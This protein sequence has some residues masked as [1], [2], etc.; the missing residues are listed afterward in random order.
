MYRTKTILSLIALAFIFGCSESD[1]RKVYNVKNF[2]AKNDGKTLATESIQSAIDKC[3]KDGGGQVLVPAGEYLVGTLNLKS[4][5]DFHIEAGATLIATT[6]LEKYQ[7]HNNHPAGVFYTEKADNVSISGRGKIFGQGMEYM[8]K[9]SAK[10]IGLDDRQFTRQGENFRRVAHGVGDGPLYPKERFHQMIIFSEC[11]RVSLSDF[12]CIDAPYWTILLV[13]C[14]GIE[15]HRVNIQNNLLIPNSDGLD[16]ISCSNANV[17]NCNFDCGDDALV[18]AGYATHFGDPGFK[19]ILRRSENIN[20]NNCIFRSRSSAI[21]IGGWDQNNMA[22]YNISNISIYDSNRGIN[23]GVG[24]SGSIQNINFTNITIETRLH[25]GDWWGQGDAIK[26]S[27]I[28]GVHENVPGIVKNINF[29]NISCTS[30]NGVIMYASDE[31]K[32]QN[33]FFNNFQ[34]NIKKSPM[35]KL[36]GGNHDLRP[37]IVPGKNIFASKIPAIYIENAD[38]VHFNQADISWDGQTEPYFTAAIEA[39]KVDGLRLYGVK[40]KSS[41]SNP[42]MSAVILNDCIDFYNSNNKLTVSY[43]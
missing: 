18:L 13:H 33:I 38:N 16:I 31:S 24:D 12:R 10:V 34:L 5:I 4:N 14:N 42:N 1:G 27:S 11:T 36:A 28:R 21:R 41:P 23:I 25:T 40:G 26:I 32:L 17:S 39:V 30:E 15:V 3:F 2:G 20:V 22:N 37:N 7:I 9:D 8:Y 6:D 29:T 43:Q 35:E 19:G